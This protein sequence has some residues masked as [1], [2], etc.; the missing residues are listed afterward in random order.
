MKPLL[1]IFFYCLP[2]ITQAIDTHSFSNSEQQATYESLT[3]E[4]RCLVC[5]NQTIADSNADLA[6]D[7]RQQIV[8]LL[9]QGKSKQEI[10]RFMTDRY[11]DFILYRP[12][13]NATTGL[14]WLAPILFLLIGLST[15]T[16]FIRSKKTANTIIDNDKLAKARDLLQQGDDR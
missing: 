2:L 1:L 3:T 11:G 14:L 8:D 5:Q 15:I 10:I 4:L 6:K 7:L 9:Q 13:F 12:A 16:L